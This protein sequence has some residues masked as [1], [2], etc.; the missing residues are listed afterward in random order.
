MLCTLRNLSCKGAGTGTTA[1]AAA[2]ASVAGNTRLQ[3]IRTKFSKPDIHVYLKEDISGLGK[4]VKYARNYLVP[5]NLGYYVPRIRGKPV[6]PE[7]W[8]P[9]L[10]DKAL[11]I[12]SISPAF[13]VASFDESVQSATAQL[14]SAMAKL[15]RI[16]PASLAKAAITPEALEAQDLERREALLKVTDLKFH[17]VRIAPDSEK[18]FGSVSSTDIAMLLDRQH[19][20]RIDRDSIVVEQ[21]KLKYIGNYTVEVRFPSGLQPAKLAIIID[22]Q[23]E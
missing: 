7:G 16:N 9:K 10:T 17:R 22:D 14:N 3:A 13:S 23:T 1:V 20:I 11:G 18:I 5:F 21:Q 6:L 12:E 19:G 4:R 2:S 15:A 8:Q